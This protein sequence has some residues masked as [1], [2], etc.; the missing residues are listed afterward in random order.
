M[1]GLDRLYNIAQ[2]GQT[3]EPTAVDN[4]MAQYKPKN[5]GGFWNGVKNFAGSNGGRMLLGGLAGTALG[6]LGG[7]NLSEALT[8]GIMGATGAAKG[9]TMRGQYNDMIARQ[10]QERAD[11]LKELENGRNFQREMQQNN[12]AAQK[13]AADLAF[14]R[15][16][17][18]IDESRRYAEQQRANEL[19]KN[20]A[21]IDTLSVDDSEKQRLKAGLRGFNLSAPKSRIET[22]QE[23]Y[24]NPDTAPERRAELEP[25]IAD[26]Y[27]FRNTLNTL[28][29]KEI[30]FTDAATGLSKLSSATDLPADSKNALAENYGIKTNFIDAPK[31]YESGDRG[32]IQYLQDQGKSLDEARRIVGM[33]TPEEKLAYEEEKARVVK[34]A[35]QPYIL[36]QQNNRAQN[37]MKI[38]EFKSG[39]PTETQRK[40]TEQAQALRV[41][42]S[43]LYQQMYD[44][45]QARIK[46]AVE[47]IYKTTTETDKIK[48]ELPY[49]GMTPQM[50]NY[51]FI[52][53]NPEAAN[54]PVFAKSGNTINVS[55]GDNIS[56]GISDKKLVEANTNAYA[57]AINNYR[58][59]MVSRDFTNRA[60]DNLI[61]SLEKDPSVVGAYS[62][63]NETF[64]RYVGDNKQWLEK[65]GAVVRQI[66]DIANILIQQ[67][68]KA[69]VTGINTVAEVERIVGNLSPTS[70]ASEIKGALAKLKVQSEELARKSWDTLE[71]FRNP[72]PD[73]SL[74][75]SQTTGQPVQSIDADGVIDYT[76]YIRG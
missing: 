42:E 20:D 46:Q 28:T 58:E 15:R 3:A 68:N 24:L 38:A 73:Y 36:E 75:S 23:E 39:L 4:I 9:I 66:N 48:A 65:R 40:I 44:E 19:S 41:P 76:D 13:E 67:A 21:Y 5:Q 18:E 33:L 60:A 69:G 61:N 34:K 25:M 52:Q 70:S 30:S 63:W 7:R 45:Q 64:Q 50:K 6:A 8:G 32:T 29:P 49:V 31:K 43:A 54:S 16:L 12:L 53:Q 57:D 62:G 59:S 14:K 27:R 10:Q 11:R 1:N 56:G 47:N 72:L 2:T 17:Q 35:E 71:S 74:Y 26:Y 37:D 51:Q 55:T 22:L